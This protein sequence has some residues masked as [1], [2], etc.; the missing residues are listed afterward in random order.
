MHSEEPGETITL[1]PPAGVTSDSQEQ[2]ALLQRTDALG[3]AAMNTDP[4]CDSQYLRHVAAGVH[5]ETER[6][7]LML[8]ADFLDEY[9]LRSASNGQDRQ[10]KQ[11]I[12]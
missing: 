4:F 2:P 7:V 12:A 1:K 10:R 9:E 6:M 8:L 11:G 5:D 3:C